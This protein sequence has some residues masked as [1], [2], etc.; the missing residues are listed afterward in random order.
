MKRIITAAVLITTLLLTFPNRA[1]HAQSPSVLSTTQLHESIAQLYKAAY[2]EEI[3][4]GFA[5]AVVKDNQVMYLEGFGYSDLEAKRKVTRDTVFYIA[6]S[7]KAFFGLT[8]ALLDEEKKIDLDAPL[9]RYLPNLKMQPPLST[10]DITLR[11][12]LTHTHGIDPGAPVVFRTAFSGEFTPELLISLL[13]K[14]KPAS[15]GRAFRYSNLGYNIAGLALDSYL[16]VG[17]KELIRRNVL[18]PLK[19]TSTTL[20]RSKVDPQRL[21]MPYYLSADGYARVAY[22]KNDANMHA[23]GGIV[24]TAEDLAK[25]LQ[26]NINAGRVG[27]KQIFPAAVIEET[28]RKFADQQTTFAEVKRYGYGLGWNLGTYEGDALVHHHGGFSAF[29]AHISFMPQHRLGVAVLAHE[30]TVGGRLAEVVA[31]HIYDTLLAKPTVKEKESRTIADF[32]KQ[33]KLRREALMTHRAERAARQKPLQHSLEAYAGVYENPDF[34]HMEWRVVNGKLEASMGLLRS[35][36]EVF[37]ATKESLRVELTPGQG[38]V[39]R[40]IFGENDT[41]AARVEYNGQRFER[42]KP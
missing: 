4:P 34:G 16:K 10:D 15:A 12:L 19:M 27:N 23:A 30:G 3:A 41:Q 37:D 24:T 13:Q 17:W 40:F 39:A 21:A 6:S 7:A 11:A 14:Y 36:A 22:A 5:V 20:Y 28:Q 26:V 29:Y 42:V 32:L 25:W 8:A 31:N 2:S 35:V 18:K 33:V 38:D 9:S 1:T